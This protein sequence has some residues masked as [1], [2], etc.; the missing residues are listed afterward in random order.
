M[1]SF[2]S[3]DPGHEDLEEEGEAAGFTFCNLV[4]GGYGACLRLLV[5][6]FCRMRLLRTLLVPIW[7]KA[8]RGARALLPLLCST[9]SG[10]RASV[11]RSYRPRLRSFFS[12]RADFNLKLENTVELQRKAIYSSLAT[13]LTRVRLLSPMQC[14]RRNALHPAH[15][16]SPIRYA[17]CLCVRSRL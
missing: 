17:T 10:M 16:F 8:L 15:G 7:A 9:C 4:F 5:S 3:A 12:L 11:L 13:A 2:L 14:I 6:R 1:C